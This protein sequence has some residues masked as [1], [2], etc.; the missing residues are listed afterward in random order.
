MAFVQAQEG[1]VSAIAR[2]G[3]HLYAVVDATVPASASQPHVPLDSTPLRIVSDTRDEPD[4]LPWL[5]RLTSNH[6]D[7]LLEMSRRDDWGI[8]VESDQT[9]EALRVELAARL[10]AIDDLGHLCFLRY[11]DPRVLEP[12]LMTLSQDEVSRW[13]AG[14]GAFGWI[15]EDHIRWLSP[16]PQIDGVAGDLVVHPLRIRTE[17]LAPFNDADDELLLDELRAFVD[18][19]RPGAFSGLPLQTVRQMLRS[20]IVRASRHKITSRA[21]VAAFAAIM[22]DV[23]PNFDEHPEILACLRL[24]LLTGGL[25]LRAAIEMCSDEA[26]EE[27][28]RDADMSAWIAN[29]TAIN[30]N[31]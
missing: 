17:H 19:Q 4:G 20:A 18:E 12:L 15:D 16:G 30:R 24:P 3:F 14:I 7:W 31:T 8:L 6:R 1:P 28:E 27:A 2:T 9:P 13:F 25:R 11:Y 21:D 5:V 23:A 29:T 22:L 26:W 10:E